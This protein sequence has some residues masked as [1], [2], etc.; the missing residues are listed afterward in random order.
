MA[1]GVLL[2]ASA[3]GMEEAEAM[4]AP[5]VPNPT[6]LCC[7]FSSRDSAPRGSLHPPT[8]AWPRQSI[9]WL[10]NRG[11]LAKGPGAGR[12]LLCAAAERGSTARGRH[13]PRRARQ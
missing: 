1:L 8:S 11:E 12:A 2:T 13:A 6:L 7:T 3:E 4:C 9:V 10:G 5:S